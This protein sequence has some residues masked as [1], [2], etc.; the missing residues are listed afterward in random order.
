MDNKINVRNILQELRDIWNSG[1]RDSFCIKSYKYSSNGGFIHTFL[2]KKPE[3]NYLIR[4]SF[5]K[6]VNSINEIEVQIG[7]KSTRTDVEFCNAERFMSRN[8]SIYL[9]LMNEIYDYRENKDA[10]KAEKAIETAMSAVFPHIY[11]KEL[12]NKNK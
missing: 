6:G 1:E 2:Y 4:V 10:F 11:D 5:L 8:V 12:L 9:K 7:E 3:T